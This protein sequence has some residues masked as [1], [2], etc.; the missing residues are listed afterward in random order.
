[1]EMTLQLNDRFTD[2]QKT[3]EVERTARDAYKDAITFFDAYAKND[4]EMKGL[5]RNL[6]KPMKNTTVMDKLNLNLTQDEVE[7]LTTLISKDE[8]QR[9][10]T[11]Y[12]KEKRRG[13]GIKSRE[14]YIATTKKYEGETDKKRAQR[15]SLTREKYLE[16]KED[17]ITQLKSELKNNPQATNKEL[18]T[19]VQTSV[20]QIQRYKKE[21]A[22]G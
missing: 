14:E 13:Q 12:Q 11:N 16:R 5:P 7:H 21:L 17:K 3:R 8:K 22:E 4:F 19:I 9:R 2:P 20:R 18:A 10:N 6:I 1:M 15:K